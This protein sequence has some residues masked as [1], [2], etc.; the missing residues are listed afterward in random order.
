MLANRIR[1][2]LLHKE[3]P[4]LVVHTE[5]ARRIGLGVGLFLFFID[6]FYVFKS[7]VVDGFCVG[8]ELCSCDRKFA[9]SV[10]VCMR[11]LN[12]IGVL[13]DVFQNLVKF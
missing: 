3:S 5:R 6:F 12:L 11:F 8:I 10:R 1:T 13:L 9:S 4:R 2:H 7:D